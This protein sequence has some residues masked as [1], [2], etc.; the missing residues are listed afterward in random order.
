MRAILGIGNTGSRYKLTRHNIGFIVLDHFAQKHSISFEPSKE[1][2]FY[3]SGS[4]NAEEYILVKPST[5]V[6][7]SGLAALAIVQA[8]NIEPED[9]LV[10]HD[11]LNLNFGNIRIRRKGGDGGHNGISSI[12]YHLNTN[13]FPRLRIG[14]GN[15]FEKGDMA[16]Y[17][18]AALTNEE[19]KVL[20]SEKDNLNELLDEFVAGG[21]QN[22]LNFYSK[23]FNTGLNNQSLNQSGD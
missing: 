2:Y 9:L 6:N 1:N 14:I 7:Q 4:L 10:V 13:Q 17:V 8:F 5:F 15:N 12:I 16:D 3:A 21:I 23:I 19:I 20:D 11:D 22:M 18:L